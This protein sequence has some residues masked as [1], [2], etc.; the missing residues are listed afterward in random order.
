MFLVPKVGTVKWRP[1]IDLSTLNRFTIVPRFKMEKGDMIRAS[2]TPRD[3]VSSVDL[4]DTYYHLSIKPRF[5]KYFRF[6][7]EGVVYQYRAI[8]FGLGT[9]P[10]D[11]TNQAKAFKKTATELGFRTNRYLLVSHLLQWMQG[12]TLFWHP[13]WSSVFRG[14]KGTPGGLKNLRSPNSIP[15]SN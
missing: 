14:S 13:R 3:W 1:V 6:M 2:L 11:F 7:F 8:P 9:A 10:L 12:Q 4:S 15:D 5:R